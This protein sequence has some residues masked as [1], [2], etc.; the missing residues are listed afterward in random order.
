[1]VVEDIHVLVSGTPV[2][3]P[4]SS[5][6]VVAPKPPV[7]VPV[8]EP[9][10]VVPVTEPGPI[11]V[12]VLVTEPRPIPVI[13]PTIPVVN[14]PNWVDRIANSPVGMELRPI[15]DEAKDREVIIEL[16][17]IKDEIDYWKSTLVGQFIGG[18]PSLVQ[19][20][21]FV[22]KYCNH[23]K[24]PPVLL[25]GHALI[26][27][28]W[29]P[30]ILKELDTVSRVPVWVTLP[31]LDPVFWSEKALSK[32]ASKIG[33]PLYADPITT[34]KERLSFARV[35]IEV[36]VSIALPHHL[37]ITSPYGQIFQHIKYEWV[38]FYCGHCKKLG[39]EIQNCRI[40]KKLQRVQK[41]PEVVVA[42]EDTP[43]PVAP[44]Q[45]VIDVPV[46]DVVTELP[47]STTKTVVELPAGSAP[48]SL[49]MKIGVWNVRGMNDA[50]K[51]HEVVSF[52]KPNNLDIMGINKTRIKYGRFDTVLNNYISHPNG[53]LWVIWSRMNMKVHVLSVGSQWI[54]LCVEEATCHKISVTFVYGLNDVAGRV[55]LWD[56]LGNSI[57]QM[58]WLVLGDL[59][60]VRTDYERISNVPPNL[61][62][63]TD[64]NNV[65]SNAG[66]EE[67]ST[68][69]HEK[70]MRLD[71]VLIN[72]V[73]LSDFPNSSAVALGAG[74]SDHSPLTVSVSSAP[75]LKPRL[76]RFLNCWIEDAKFLPI[77]TEV[78]KN[79][80][81]G[82][83][84]YRL[85]T[86]LK[87]VKHQLKLLHQSGFS[88][89]SRRDRLHSS[90][91]DSL[92]LEEEKDICQEFCKMKR[93]E[94]SIAYQRAKIHDI[95]MM[96]AIVIPR[97]LARRL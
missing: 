59:N 63:M 1:M 46:E 53:R 84:M 93:I 23:V 96:D 61:S 67:M 32:I 31:N 5:A 75:V 16:D 70:W 60:C 26:L 15:R 76:F 24:K 19:V 58:P 68:F 37:V 45:E 14:R 48:H 13:V 72:S 11:P 69:G 85:V 77:V 80:V 47:A 64:F 87:E 90:P 43:P 20:Q 41:P 56:F 55:A 62:V 4:P 7:V 49:A 25:G 79:N 28:Q 12:V 22:S 88:N 81:R 73:W 35:M 2:V 18:K 86:H 91:M 54:H 42:L 78:W 40:H 66:L 74:V 30:Q 39:H 36:D 27:K 29:N 94:L 95:K 38:P 57:T 9:G 21:E 17:D 8:A 50:I 65:I 83:P 44:V 52:F 33:T 92:L 71:R 34:H 6:T 82:C 3:E 51:Q 97:I 10:V 89:V